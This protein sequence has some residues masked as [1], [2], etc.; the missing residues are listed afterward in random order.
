MNTKNLPPFVDVVFGIPCVTSYQ[1]AKSFGV[2]HKEMVAIIQRVRHAAGPVFSASNIHERL[3]LTKKTYVQANYLIS[4]DAFILLLG[5]PLNKTK[6]AA[7][8][9]TAFNKAEPGGAQ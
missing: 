3:T 7:Q 1:I 4:R 2:P 8:Y 6:V 5:D 9:L